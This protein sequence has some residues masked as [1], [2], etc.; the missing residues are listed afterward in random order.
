MNI[1]IFIITDNI[2]WKKIMQIFISEVC[3]SNW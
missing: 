1:F 3:V 2:M